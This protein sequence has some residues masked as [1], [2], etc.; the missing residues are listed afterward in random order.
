LGV[1]ALL[2]LAAG[3]Y[4]LFFYGWIPHNASFGFLDIAGL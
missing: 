4:G 2:G 3:F 1:V